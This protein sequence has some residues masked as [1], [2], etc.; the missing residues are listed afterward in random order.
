MFSLLLHSA[1]AVKSQNKPTSR[2]WENRLHLLRGGDAKLHCKG[3]DRGTG[4]ELGQFCNQITTFRLH[5][6]LQ[7]GRSS[8]SKKKRLSWR[9][10]FPPWKTSERGTERKACYHRWSHSTKLLMPGGKMISLTCMSAWHHQSGQ[11]NPK[12][13]GRVK[14]KVVLCANKKKNCWPAKSFTL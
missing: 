14:V 9:C 1:N 13:N 12:W 10:L 11:F 5:P 4:R 7:S 8:E 3:M 2:E 6:P